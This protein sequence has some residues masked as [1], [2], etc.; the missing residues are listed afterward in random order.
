M[1]IRPDS[2]VLSRNFTIPTLPSVVQRIQ[3]LLEQPDAGVREIAAVVA[4]DAPL[5][6]KVL[7]IANSSFYGLREKVVS[8]RHAASV[9]GVR[10]LRGVVTQASVIK[11]FEHL[12]GGP[13]DLEALWRHSILCAQAS[14]FAGR[15]A[16]GAIGLAPDELHACGLLHDLGK[17]VLLD[18]LRERYLGLVS[19]AQERQVELVVVEREALGFDH[20][21]VGHVV[22]QRWGLP[23]QVCTAILLHHAPR[24]RAAAEPAALL[25]ERCNQFVHA[26]ERHGS[27]AAAAIFD[28][29]AL[30]VLGLQSRDVEEL[31]AFVEAARDSVEI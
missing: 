26:C 28:R 19:A 4:E 16:R 18:N 9:L 6:A 20:A 30:R 29:D 25:V 3:K 27:G 8:T 10:V 17:V 7:K 31:S 23:A 1:S 22:A 5:A 11:Q 21:E 24:E 15:R 2:P 12:E 13:F 14:Q